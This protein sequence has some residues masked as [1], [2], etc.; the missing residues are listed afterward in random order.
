MIL[1]I[2]IYY[3]PKGNG[4]LEP[5]KQLTKLGHLEE[6]K[7]KKNFSKLDYLPKR[8]IKWSKLYK[9]NGEQWSEPE[10]SAQSINVPHETIPPKQYQAKQNKITPPKAG[11]SSG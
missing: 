5:L 8:S 2:Y 10:Q 6:R 11:K 7:E 9:R 4:T 1:Y 3:T